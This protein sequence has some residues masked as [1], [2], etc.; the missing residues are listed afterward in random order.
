MD[1]NLETLTFLDV[2]LEDELEEFDCLNEGHDEMALELWNKPL[3]GNGCLPHLSGVC[4]RGTIAFCGILVF[5][6]KMYEIEQDCS[7][8]SAFWL[9][10]NTLAS[11]IC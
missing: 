5:Y 3:S 11:T 8:T 2:V 1:R 6:V 10:E 9:Y 4:E 7:R